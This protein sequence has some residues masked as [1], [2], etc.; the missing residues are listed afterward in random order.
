MPV[1]PGPAL[2]WLRVRPGGIY[3]DCTAGAGGHSEEIAR[4]LGPG[5][6]IALDADPAAVAAA[7]QRLKPYPGALVLHRNY[8]E[9]ADVLS[10]SGIEAVDGVLIDAGISSMQLDDPARGFSFQQEGPLDMRLDPG[11][12]MTALDYLRSVE[13]DE[14]ARVLRTYGDVGPARRIS[15]ALVDGA[16]AG[17]IRT[18]RDLAHAVGT[19]L[20]ISKAVP[21]E[22]RTVFQAIRIALNDE[23]ARLDSGL[24][25]AVNAL[26]PEGRLVAISFHSGEDKIVKNVLRDNARAIRE[27]HPDGR[28]R[29]VHPP[30]LRVLTPKPIQPDAEEIRRNPRSQSAKLRAAERLPAEQEV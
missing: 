30:R 17:T 15:R 13:P 7:T 21:D 16:R 20:G 27:R 3:I 23:L 14:L 8:S 26:A 10:E 12:G 9:L 11:R 2:E 1:L 5:R 18:T 24:R 29:V 22:A 19:G 6:L 28:D 4:R 25:Q